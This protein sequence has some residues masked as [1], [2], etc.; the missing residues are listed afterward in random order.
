MNTFSRHP[1]PSFEEVY[2]KAPFAELIRLALSLTE[3]VVKLRA[4]LTRATPP[5]DIGH[6]AAR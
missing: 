2:P 5:A 6:A 4:R 1:Q 3:K